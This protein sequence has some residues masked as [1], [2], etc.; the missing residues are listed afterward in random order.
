[1]V[2]SITGRSD[3]V[4]REVAVET[5]TGA[6]TAE[7]EVSTAMVAQAAGCRNNEVREVPVERETGAETVSLLWLHPLQRLHHNSLLYQR[8]LAMP[9][10]ALRYTPAMAHGEEAAS[11]QVPPRHHGEEAVSRQVLPRA[12]QLDTYR[13]AGLTTQL[14]HT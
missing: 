3:S 14:V 11:R 2:A 1:M 5:E 13:L 4:A 12:A 9:N 6:E 7:A 10:C 8:A